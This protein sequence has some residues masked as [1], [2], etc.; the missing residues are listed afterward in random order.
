[1]D[2]DDLVMAGLA[3]NWVGMVDSQAGMV[4]N[5]NA[6]MGD[7]LGGSMVDSQFDG[8]DAAYYGAFHSYS[9]TYRF[10]FDSCS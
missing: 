4:G 6:S 2:R 7:T 5:P 1:M 10:V 3:D 9:A 8:H